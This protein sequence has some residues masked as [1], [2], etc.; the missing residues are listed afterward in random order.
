MSD[1]VS[2]VEMLSK[3]V[4][5]REGV[6]LPHDQVINLY[7]QCRWSSAEKPDALLFAL[8]NSETLISAWYQNILIGLGNAISDKALTVYYPHL[9]V[10]PSYQKMGIG[11]ELMKRLQAPYVNFHQQILLAIDYA[12]PFYEKLGF[13]QAQ[14]VQ[15]MWIYDESDINTINE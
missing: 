11:R 7:S 1:S 13:K 9:L 14:G 2:A 3:E 5:Y 10:L 6:E 8:S 12:A 15:T 4:E